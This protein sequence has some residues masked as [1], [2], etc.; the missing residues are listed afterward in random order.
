MTQASNMISGEMTIIEP[1]G[2]TF[3]EQLIAASYN[4]TEFA[5]YTQNP[6]ILQ[7]EFSGYDDAG[8]IIA[9][10]TSNLYKKRFPILL[11][12]VKINLT[13]KGT[14]YR[15]A[16]GKMTHSLQTREF[17][18]TPKQVTV[19]GAKTVGEFFT[20]FQDDINTFL[21]AQKTTRQA[22]FA[23]SLKFDIEPTIANS[24]IVISKEV[25]VTDSDPTAKN[26]KISGSTITIPSGTN[27]GSVITR[28]M[29]HSEYLLSQVKNNG[30]TKPFNAFKVNAKV[31]F[32]G[33][34][35]ATS[36]A[37]SPG[38][39]KTNIDHYRNQPPKQYIVSIKQY[40][41]WKSE[42]PDLPA[43]ADSGPYTVKKYNYVYTGQ[44]IDI[45][46]IKMDFDAAW[47]QSVNGYSYRN[48]SMQVTQSTSQFKVLDLFPSINL[49]SSF[50]ATLI[51]QLRSVSNLMPF[52]YKP[53][54]P[55]A[56]NN[57]GFGTSKSPATQRMVEMLRQGVYTSSAGSM[58]EVKL[59]IIGD[60]TFLKQ[61][62]WYYIP[63]PSSSGSYDAAIPQSQFV[64]KWG[65]LRMDS[66][67]MVVSL[68]INGATDID[69]DITNQGG[70]YPP[71]GSAPSIFSGQYHIIQINNHFEKGVFKQV[72]HLARYFNSDLTKAFS[73]APSA[74]RVPSGTV[75]VLPIEQINA[76]GNETRAQPTPVTTPVSAIG[77]QTQSTIMANNNNI[78]VGGTPP[79]SSSVI[80]AGNQSGIL[81]SP[82]QSGVLLGA[83]VP[84]NVP[85]AVAIPEPI[86]VT[87]SNDRVMPPG[88]LVRT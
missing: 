48:P 38:G 52:R 15:I 42:H 14:E 26:I 78:T 64:A 10:S 71:I 8:N 17:G 83:V 84:N 35:G 67:D 70:V 75:T 34:G 22:E 36:T 68:T 21:A 16:F 13:Q 49:T 37:A 46:D 58:L 65:H 69:I 3:I 47:Y 6:Y 2:I 44:N 19:N 28:I 72:L 57:Q 23:D 85:G 88:T 86:P 59:T 33:D 31:G 12:D 5:N 43:A 25:P 18:T 32:I 74:D 82:P 45:T 4:G 73:N 41:T 56:N 51:P 81:I 66:E 54:L 27:M 20:K 39:T 80:V 63:S 9:N 29:A 30:Q 24:T 60:P 40:T 1:V 55:D 79:Q 62:D 61:D 7:L 76:P 53:S 87:A 11:L 50:L 77:D